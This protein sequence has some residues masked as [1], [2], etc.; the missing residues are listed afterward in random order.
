MKKIKD[1]VAA[2]V[3]HLKQT[4]GATWSVACQPRA[5]LASKR[6][7]P[8]RTEGPWKAIEALGKSGTSTSGSRDT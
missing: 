5:K 4:L 7:Q 1:D 6:V 8:A 2:V 3:K